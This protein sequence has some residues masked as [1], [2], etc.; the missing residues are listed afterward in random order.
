MI[1]LLRQAYR[2]TGG[3]YGTLSPK[4]QAAEAERDSRELVDTLLR[5]APDR[6]AIRRTVQDAVQS[7]IVADRMRMIEALEQLFKTFMRA[8]LAGQPDLLREL[9]VRSTFVL[10]RYRLTMSAAHLDSVVNG[11][12]APWSLA[13]LPPQA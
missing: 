4:E 6:D 8:E 12:D 1:K 11:F 7:S 10:G 9:T 3:Y 13:D 2:A 5:G